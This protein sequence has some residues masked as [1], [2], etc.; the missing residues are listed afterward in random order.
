MIK[1]R[2][3]ILA[4][5][6]ALNLVNYV[7][8]FVITAISPRIQQSFGLG[9]GAIG[10]V[11]TAFMIGYFVTSP[12]FGWLGD[13]YPRKALIAGGVAVWSV[14]TMLSGLANG[15]G[16][17]VAARV[18]VGVGEAS[19]ATLAPTIIDDIATKETRSRLLSIFYVA[20]PVGSAL[21][22]LLGG[23]LDRW[24]GW[25]AAFYLAGGPGIL[26]ALATLAIREPA[27]AA[28][29]DDEPQVRGRAAALALAR[30]PF[31]VATV[32]GYTAQTFALGGFTAWA[33]PYLYRAFG[34]ELHVA[35]TW[36]GAITVI[37]GLVGTAVGGFLGDRWP[38]ADRT[39][40]YLRVCAV[41]SA[42]ATPLALLAFVMPSATS[43]LIALGACELAVFASVSPTNA[44]VLVSAPA[45]LRASA[46]AVSIFAIHALGDVVSPPIVGGI[47]DLYGDPRRGLQIGML[48]LP[49]A[50]ALSGVLWWR[51]ARARSHEPAEAS[52]SAPA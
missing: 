28:H 11:I 36:F 3:G 16:T 50:L 6:T 26:L 33:V 38:G 52:P 35:N 13:R 43:Y 7:D 4:L 15:F 46:M 21:G 32:A 31:Y 14:A 8:R 5:L 12:V 25:R 27:R 29:D 9:D 39:R 49:L 37:T 41:S 48:V 17:M 20:I 42:V 2:S 45:A 40:A 18:L 1:S 44:A 22:F 34:L 19:Y 10:V 30:R 47:S 24:F 23:W 51:G